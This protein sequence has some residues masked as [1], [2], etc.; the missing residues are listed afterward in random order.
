MKVG[1]ENVFPTEVE[2]FLGGHPSVEAAAV[3][4]V[5]D[6]RLDEVVAAFVQLSRGATATEDELVAYCRG[7]LASFKV[8]R[9]IRF[10]TTWEMSA[11]KIRKEPLRRRLLEELD[12][13]G[14]GDAG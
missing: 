13:E 11:T 9:M 14:A 12:Q 2:D 6:A 1:G 5:P 10:V 3:V 4:G 7:R 8:P